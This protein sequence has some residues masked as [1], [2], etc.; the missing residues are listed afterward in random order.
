MNT[1]KNVEYGIKYREIPGIAFPLGRSLPN[2]DNVH[3]SWILVNCYD[4]VLDGIFEWF[5]FL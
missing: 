4:I 5:N 3:H 1:L 2:H